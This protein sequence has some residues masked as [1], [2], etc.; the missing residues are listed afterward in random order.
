M[1]RT[2]VPCKSGLTLKEG[3]KRLRSGNFCKSLRP[4]LSLSG[5]MLYPLIEEMI[6]KNIE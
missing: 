1:N 6:L 2:S 3:Q 5:L 4:T